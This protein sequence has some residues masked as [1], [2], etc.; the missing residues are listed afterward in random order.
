MR[1]VIWVLFLLCF[2]ASAVPIATL[3][4]AVS[5]VG[6]SGVGDK[7]K[8]LFTSK[9]NIS[10]KKIVIVTKDYTNNGS[11][12]RVYL[13]F[14][15]QDFLVEELKKM[16]AK[17]TISNLEQLAKDHPDGLHVLQWELTA[18]NRTS[19]EYS[20]EYPPEAKVSFVVVT[21][22][23]TAEKQSLSPR[24]KRA[25]FRLGKSSTEVTDMD[26]SKTKPKTEQPTPPK[27]NVKNMTESKS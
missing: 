23:P 1:K 20:V 7:I 9:E 27:P 21:Y 25:I 4:L 26:A 6:I 10:L 13:I 18:K 22:S 24:I 12:V 3:G 14:V 11:A 2:E 16:S 15:Y 8:D 19:P 5:A 17:D